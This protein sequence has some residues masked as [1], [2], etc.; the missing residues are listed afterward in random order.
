MKP[1]ASI[2]T[3]CGSFHFS[4]GVETWPEAFIVK[5]LPGNGTFSRSPIMTRAL[6]IGVPAEDL[7]VTVAPSRKSA[8][9]VL[10]SAAFSGGVDDFFEQPKPTSATAR[11]AT[12]YFLD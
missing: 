8:E 7:T 12:A 1:G 5:T 10:P 11:I 2:V 3:G 4:A 6:A 9:V